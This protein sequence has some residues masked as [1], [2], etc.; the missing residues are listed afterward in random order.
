MR[1][2]AEGRIGGRNDLD[3]FG[4][5]HI[6]D[7]GTTVGFW[8]GDAPEAAGGELVEFGD[9]QA[10]LAIPYAGLDGE[11]RGELVC[12]GNRLGVRA[13]HMGGM[14]GLG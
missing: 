14:S 10:S 13:D 9:G 2:L 1:D 3:H 11:T 6:G 5:G 4:H 8:H 7:A 12:D